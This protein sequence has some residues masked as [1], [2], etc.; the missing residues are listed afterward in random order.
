MFGVVPTLGIYQVFN[1]WF[2]GIGS[3][4][5]VFLCMSFGAV[6]VECVSNLFHFFHLWTGLELSHTALG[7]LELNLIL[8][9]W[10]RQWQQKDSTVVILVFVRRIWCQ[11]HVSRHAVLENFKDESTSH[12]LRQK[13]R[14][15]LVSH[16]NWDSAEAAKSAVVYAPMLIISMARLCDWPPQWIQKS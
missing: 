15:F 2:L 16:G 4:I 3:P 10:Q 8:G 9:T 5:M 7:H 6:E 11:L 14:L 1:R 13:A 12:F